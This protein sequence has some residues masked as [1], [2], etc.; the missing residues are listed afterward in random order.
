MNPSPTTQAIAY[1]TVGVLGGM[2]PLATVDFLQKLVVATPA[3]CDQ[4]HIP[5]L[6]RFCPEIPDRANALLGRGASPESALVA[7]ARDLERGGAQCLAIP[8]NTAHAWFEPIARAISIPVLHIADAALR[9]TAAQGGGGVTGLLA[10]SG[11]LVSGIYQSRGGAAIQWLTSTEDEQDQW[12]MQ[13]IRAIKANALDEG[14]NLLRRAALALKQ[15]GATSVVMGCTEI[16][17]V[18]AG[19]D[20]GVPL[21]DSTLALAQ[22]CVRWAGT[23]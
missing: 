21:I 9:A 8:C 12:V 20:I 5:L 13:G 22:E 7:A 6:V 19:Q 14:A 2:G 16:P 17:I 4:E 3:S 18:L 1:R 15:R 10:T 11:T 23:A